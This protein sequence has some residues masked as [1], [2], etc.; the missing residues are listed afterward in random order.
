MSYMLTMRTPF[1][2][3]HSLLPLLATHP[4][5]IYRP[6]SFGNRRTATASGASSVTCTPVSSGI[7]RPHAF[8][9][10]MPSASTFCR[11]GEG[12]VVFVLFCDALSHVLIRW[13]QQLPAPSCLRL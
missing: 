6:I 12:A 1:H 13:G 8:R 10:H 9:P 3:P 11:L 4:Y 5:T 2:E 7:G